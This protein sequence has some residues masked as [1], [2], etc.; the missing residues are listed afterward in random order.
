MRAFLDAN[1][2]VSGLLFEGNEATLLE[3]GR[4]KAITLTTNDYV[5]GEVKRVLG[6]SEFNLTHREEDGLMRYLTGC[7]TLTRD[8]NPDEVA[9]FYDL[10][11]DKKDL[12]VVVGATVAGVDYLV[13]GDKE[14]L[15]KTR[16]LV[17]TVTTFRFLEL[18]FEGK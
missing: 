13:T 10:L 16:R 9:P 18:L 6:R 15:L 17:N 4:M 12:P 3:L 5:L 7:L 1:T 8:P 2:I 11:D 14:L